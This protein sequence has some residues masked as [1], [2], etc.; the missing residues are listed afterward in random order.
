[1]VQFLVV[2]V[3][4]VVMLTLQAIGDVHVVEH[5]NP[6]PQPVQPKA[7]PRQPKPEPPQRV[8]PRRQPP[9]KLQPKTPAHPLKAG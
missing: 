5:V 8:G 9:P 1:M 2:V 6:K 4:P 7:A 3:V